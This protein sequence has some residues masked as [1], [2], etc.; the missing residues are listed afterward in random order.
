MINRMWKVIADVLS[1]IQLTSTQLTVSLHGGHFPLTP[2]SGQEAWV[3]DIFVQIH[4]F[5]IEE[6]LKRKLPEIKEV[7]TLVSGL[8]N[9]LFSFDIWSDFPLDFQSTCIFFQLLI[10]RKLWGEND[11]SDSLRIDYLKTWKAAVRHSNFPPWVGRQRKMDAVR[12]WSIPLCISRGV[13][14]ISIAPLVSAWDVHVQR[15]SQTPFFCV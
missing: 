3:S 11:L 14:L 15:V 12:I 7:V 4:C 8:S 2:P 9:M 5:L 13:S 10:I 1:E 6:Q